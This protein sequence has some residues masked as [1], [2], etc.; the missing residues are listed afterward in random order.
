MLSK[1]LFNRYGPKKLGIETS[2]RFKIF[3]NIKYFVQ[4]VEGLEKGEAQLFS[5]RF[6]ENRG[7]IWLLRVGSPF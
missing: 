1:A 6:P 3:D 2:D 4:N 7:F 5:T